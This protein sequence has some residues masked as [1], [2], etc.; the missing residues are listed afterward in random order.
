MDKVSEFLTKI[1][2]AGLAKHEKI[3]VPASKM[4]E[5]IAKILVEEGFL[6]SYKIAKDSKQG[7][8]RL[9][10]KYDGQGQ[11][12]ISSIERTSRAGRRVFVK[13]REIPPV[14]SGAGFCILSTNKG[15]LSSKAA[16]RE[17]LG[18]ELICKIW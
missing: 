11:H 12:S 15:L 13:G 14:R 4:R 16:S 2:N 5:G 7:V 8:M 17:N 10:L 1:R 3:D 9:Y 6:R 18:G